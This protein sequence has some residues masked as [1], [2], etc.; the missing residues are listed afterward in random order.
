MNPA[1]LSPNQLTDMEND[2]LKSFVKYC[3][4]H[5]TER[6]WQSLR[7]WADADYILLAHA[8]NKKGVLESVMLDGIK[9]YVEDTFNK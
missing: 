5:P 9:L 8:S 2:K 3:E 4:E 6:F 1:R 7:N